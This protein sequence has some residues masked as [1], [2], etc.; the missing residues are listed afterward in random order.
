MTSNMDQKKGLGEK[1]EGG[2]VEKE[3]E[4]GLKGGEGRGRKGK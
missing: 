1:M 3:K 4:K 2:G